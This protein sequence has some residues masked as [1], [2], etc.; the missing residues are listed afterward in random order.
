[1]KYK[2][3]FDTKRKILKAILKGEGVPLKEISEKK[4]KRTNGGKEPKFPK[5]MPP[6]P[7]TWGVLKNHSNMLTYLIPKPVILYGTKNGRITGRHKNGKP[8]YGGFYSITQHVK[9]GE[10]TQD[11]IDILTNSKEF[12]EI[13]E[14]YKTRAYEVLS[15]SPVLVD[16]ATGEIINPETE[17]E[18]K[19]KTTET[20]HS[21]TYKNNR[22]MLE[23]LTDSARWYFM[24]DFA[25]ITN[26]M[27]DLEKLTKRGRLKYGK[28]ENGPD[29]T[30]TIEKTGSFCNFPV[31]SIAMHRK[32]KGK[33]QVD[34]MR[35]KNKGVIFYLPM[36][37]KDEFTHVEER[38]ASDNEEKPLKLSDG[39]VTQTM[40]FFV[41]PWVSDL[42]DSGYVKKASHAKMKDREYRIK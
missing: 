40:N 18:P 4:L 6:S 28:I 14:K 7:S 11:D 27:K 20:E 2:I 38:L 21:E 23:N 31:Y 16:I 34:F 10:I 42:T 36:H 22:E 19:Q 29:G 25:L 37:I 8:I 32:Q 1:M 33:L 13:N 26:V 17:S 9:N 24:L 39:N 5:T 35:V 41:E 3:V 12:N 30:L 15:Q